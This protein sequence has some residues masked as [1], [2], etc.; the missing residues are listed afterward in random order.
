MSQ[1]QLIISKRATGQIRARI[2]LKEQAPP[3]RAAI[4]G[5]LS[6]HQNLQMDESTGELRKPVKGL[7]LEAKR[8]ISEYSAA[9]ERH[10]GKDHCIFLTGTLPGS[11]MESIREIAKCQKVIQRRLRQ[12]L[13]DV[14]A[15]CVAAVIVWEFQKR[16]ALHLHCLVGHENSRVLRI[17]RRGFRRYWVGLLDR[18]S[19]SSGVDLFAKSGGGSHRMTPHVVRAWAQPVRKSVAAYLAKYLSKSFTGVTLPADISVSRLWGATAK[20]RGLC[21]SFTD[22]AVS[23]ELH[24]EKALAL[25]DRVQSSLAVAAVPLFSWNRRHSLS[26]RALAACPSYTLQ[27]SLYSQLLQTLDCDW[28]PG[29]IV[30]PVQSTDDAPPLGSLGAALSIFGGR[31]I[32]QGDFI[33]TA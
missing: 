25:F 15:S 32:S 16:G 23:V 21:R 8:M 3:P 6:K 17:I 5:A 22:I 2:R 1:A 33:D 19:T 10:Y 31:L 12:W 29:V 30:F 20:A 7:R 27:G 13:A 11:T 28:V 26:E 14:S 9:I 24:I 18:L 4:G